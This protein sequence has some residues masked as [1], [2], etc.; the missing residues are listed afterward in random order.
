LWNNILNL[1]E[2]LALDR[3]EVLPHLKGYPLLQHHPPHPLLLQRPRVIQKLPTFHPPPLGE[4]KVL[5]LQR[6]ALVLGVVES[7]PWGEELAPWGE[8]LAPNN[9]ETLNLNFLK[10]ILN[11]VN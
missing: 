3:F 2:D 5:P 10:Y 4:E 8:E 7:A 6:Q 11:L 9:E 1:L